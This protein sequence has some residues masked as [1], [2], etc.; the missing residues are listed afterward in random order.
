MVIVHLTVLSC[1]IPFSFYFLFP[2]L[3]SIFSENVGRLRSSVVGI[4][5]SSNLPLLNR[6]QNVLTSE[7]GLVVVSVA[8]LHFAG[9]FVG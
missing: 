9:F 8:L 3:L 4:S 2:F 6:A 7:F 1:F 5:F